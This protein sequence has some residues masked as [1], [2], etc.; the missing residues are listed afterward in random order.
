MSRLIVKNLPFSIT[1]AKLRTTFAKHG[2][3]TDLQ[4]KYKDGKFRGFAFIG[5]QTD[6]EAGAAKKYLDGTFVGAAK[7]KVEICNE[8]GES[9]RK[10]D[11]KKEKNESEVKKKADGDAGE[12]DIV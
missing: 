5:Y 8:L 7:I 11:K 4:L 2:S 10:K 9:S 3:V 12:L 6:A 1:E